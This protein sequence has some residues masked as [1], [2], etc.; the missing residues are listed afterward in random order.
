VP[1][2]QLQ[3]VLCGGRERIFRFT[4]LSWKKT[5]RQKIFHGFNFA[6]RAYSPEVRD[7]G[8]TGGGGERRR[9]ERLQQVG[10]QSAAVVVFGADGAEHAEARAAVAVEGV[11]VV[12]PRQ[13]Q[14]VVLVVGAHHA[15]LVVPV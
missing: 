12:E 15:D 3:A 13:G 1:S 6:T 7:D 8:G 5:R 14:L 10:Q 4:T 9:A 2:S 11:V